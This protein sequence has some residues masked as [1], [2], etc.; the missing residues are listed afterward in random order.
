MP[1]FRREDET[2]E[3]PERL[4]LLPLRDVVV[5]PYMMLPLLVGR[6]ASVNAIRAAMEKDRLVF[7]VA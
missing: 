7:A 4:P 5:F 3:A 1:T 6:T 2:V